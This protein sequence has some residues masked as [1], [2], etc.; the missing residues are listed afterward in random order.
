MHDTYLSP[1]C[2]VEDEAALWFGDELNR[3]VLCLSGD[4]IPITSVGLFT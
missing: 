2:G 4:D 1:D 3:L